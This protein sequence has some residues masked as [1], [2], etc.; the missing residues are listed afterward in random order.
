MTISGSV[1]N[2]ITQFP[3]KVLMYLNVFPCKTCTL[4]SVSTCVRT[5]MMAKVTVEVTQEDHWS[6]WMLI[7][8]AGELCIIRWR[9]DLIY[10]FD[11]TRYS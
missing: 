7:M 9:S 6:W 5:M 1:Q 2:V 10:S 3:E 11:F 8:M 4:F